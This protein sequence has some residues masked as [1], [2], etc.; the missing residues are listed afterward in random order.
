MCVYI[1]IYIELLT[2]NY[3]SKQVDKYLLFIYYNNMFPNIILQ[4]LTLIELTSQVVIA[5]L[6]ILYTSPLLKCAQLKTTMQV[7]QKLRTA[8]ILKNKEDTGLNVD[9]RWLPF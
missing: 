8:Y 4:T 1:H 6:L 2:W 7:F 9:I 3:K 5:A